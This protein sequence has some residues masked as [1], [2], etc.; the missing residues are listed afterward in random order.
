MKNLSLWQAILIAG[1]LAGTMDILAAIF[2]LAKGNA[3]GVLKYVASGALGKA[4]L[5]GDNTMALWGLFFHFLI[6]MIWAKVYFLAYP[7]LPF[8]KNNI[9]INAIIYGLVVWCIMNLIVVPLSQIPPR[10]FN[11]ENALKNMAILCFCIGFPIAW[12][13]DKYFKQT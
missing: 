8:L 10:P 13:A 4:A 9:F 1:L 6:A 7:Y 2:I 11:W 3:L 5:E 12:L